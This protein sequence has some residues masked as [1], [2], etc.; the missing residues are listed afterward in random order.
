[1]MKLTFL[2]TSDSIPS[3]KRNPTAILLNFYDENITKYIALAGSNM[4]N[5]F[6][7]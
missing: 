1:M 4:C 2:G 7:V 5:K 6:P 3:I